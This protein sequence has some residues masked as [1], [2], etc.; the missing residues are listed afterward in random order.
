M[1]PTRFAVVRAGWR[2]EFFLRIA[3]ALPQRFDLA[4]LAV[5]G[6]GH[7]AAVEARWGRPTFRTAAELLASL[8]PEFLVSSV[9][10]AA[11]FEGNLALLDTRVPVFTETPPAATLEQMR[12]LWEAVRSQG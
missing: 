10:Y 11:N 12:L 6:L 4:G 8:Q 2:T 7:A 5:R 9:A 1:K 3:P